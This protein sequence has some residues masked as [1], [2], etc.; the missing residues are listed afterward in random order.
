MRMRVSVPAI[1]LAACL[2][3]CATGNSGSTPQTQALSK[4]KP[5]MSK[6]QA[7]SLVAWY[8]GLG[9]TEYTELTWAVSSASEAGARG[10]KAAFHRACVKLA[11]ATNTAQGAPPIPAAVASKWYTVAL[12]EYQQ[13]VTVCK[14]GV[15][16]YG[17]KTVQ[18]A[19][20]GLKAANTDLNRAASVVITALS[21]G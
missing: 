20:L 19:L 1:V 2:A 5:A 16:H 15:A 8:H 9:G 14:E 13:A 18:R 6:A 7:A 11:A 12:G 10:S 21:G 17:P 4:P 3:G